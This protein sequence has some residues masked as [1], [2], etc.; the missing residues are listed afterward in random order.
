MSK[1]NRRKEY[2]RLIKLGRTTD[3]TK[4]LIAEFGKG[5][6]SLSKSLPDKDKSSGTAQANQKKVKN[7]K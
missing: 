4:D 2:D 6:G 3:I 1:E 5:P 7:G